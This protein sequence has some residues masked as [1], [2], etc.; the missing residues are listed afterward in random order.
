MEK[1]KRRLAYTLVIPVVIFV[2]LFVIY[3]VIELF[4]LSFTDTVLTNPESGLFVGFKS[5][6]KI[7]QDPVT[8]IALKNTFSYVFFGVAITVV[9]GLLVGQL[10]SVDRVITRITSGLILVPW[11][12]PPV[13]IAAAWKWMLHPQLGVI[14]DLL[15]R[16]HLIPKAIGFLSTPRLALPALIGVLVWR[17]FPLQSILISGGIQSIPRERH[18]AAIVDGASGIQRFLYIT[19][20]SIRFITLTTTIMNTLWILNSIALVLIMTGGGPLHFSELLTTHIY[21]TGF[22]FYKFGEASAIAAFN[23]LFVFAVSIGYLLIFKQVWQ[24]VVRKR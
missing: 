23:F 21:K 22:K 18:E 20:P 9:L 3:P 5:Y 13:I 1:Q 4:R 12:M 16:A 19:L 7:F 15:R 24:R 2:V 14:N 11:A 6:I 17:L 10:L 8:L